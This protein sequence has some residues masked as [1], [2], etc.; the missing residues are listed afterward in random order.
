MFNSISFLDTLGSFVE[1]ETPDAGYGKVPPALC[2]FDS[3]QCRI[4]SKAPYFISTRKYA[5]DG[6]KVIFNCNVINMNR[7]C[8]GKLSTEDFHS[9]RLH[10]SGVSCFAVQ[11]SPPK[12]TSRSPNQDEKYHTWLT[13][14]LLKLI[15]CFTLKRKTEFR[16]ARPVNETQFFTQFTLNYGQRS[17]P[18]FFF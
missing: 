17:N 11:P 10:L 3:I 9:G 5:F 6:E 8:A 7:S 2:H 1:N 4:Y 12:C 18:T 16:T 14:E 15:N 13:S